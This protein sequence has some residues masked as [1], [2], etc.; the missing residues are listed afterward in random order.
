MRIAAAMPASCSLPTSTGAE[1]S[2]HLY[3]TWALL[4]DDE[5]SRIAWFVLNKF[6]GDPSLL[7]PG[8]AT[9]RELTGV[10]TLGLLPAE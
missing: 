6:R 9:L 4:L 2:A 3:G 5:R 1:R 10:P 8:P 7:D